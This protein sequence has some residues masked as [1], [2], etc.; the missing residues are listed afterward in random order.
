MPDDSEASR[1]AAIIR[2]SSLDSIADLSD[3]QRTGIRRTL[4][5]AIENGKSVPATAG[6]IRGMLDLTDAQQNAVDSYRAL[7]QGSSARALGRDLRDRRYDGRLQDAIDNGEVL[8]DP[9]I[10]RMVDRYAAIMLNARAETIARTEMLGAVSAARQEAL[11]EEVELG[12][13]DP[14]SVRRRWNAT[15]DKRTRDS[16]AE[17]DGQTV[18]LDEPF[19]SGLGNELMYPGDPDAPAEDRINCRCVV[20]HEFS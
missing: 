5:R 20:T 15:K 1:A 19:I 7:L 14:K 10:N 3:R 9:Q 4:A 8:S 6:D 17:M 11:H 18:G 16:H 12:G 2:D 13:F